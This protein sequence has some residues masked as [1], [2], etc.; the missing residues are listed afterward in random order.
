MHRFIAMHW[1]VSAEAPSRQVEAWRAALE[2]SSLG[3]AA[4]LDTP[5]LLVLAHGQRGEPPVTT[6][7]ADA[8][9]V[10]VGPLFARGRE[11]EGR[12]QFLCGAST[13]R[14]LATAGDDLLKD[15]WGQYVAL[16]REPGAEC[17]T[18]VRDPCGAVSCFR[19][20]TAGVDLL[21]SNAA[22]I[23]DLPGVTTSIDWD[24]L[25]AFLLHSYFTTPH[26]GIREMTE[27]LAGQRLVL[28]GNRGHQLSWAWTAIAFAADP[29]LRSLGELQAE[30]RE[31]TIAC[32]AALATGRRRILVQLSGGLD[33]SILLAILRRVSTCEVIA[34]HTISN[35]YEA[36]EFALAHLV[37][38]QTGTELVTLQLDP[39]GSDLGSIRSIPKL[40]RPS[41]QIVGYPANQMIADVCERYEVDTSMAGHGGDSL[42]LQRSATRNTVSDYLQ[43]KGLGPDAWQI[44]YDAAVLEERS[45]WSILKQALDDTLTRS[46]WR[47][48]ADLEGSHESQVSLFKG[49]SLKDIPESYV[50]H[51][52]LDAAASL[53][54][55]KAEHLAAIVGLYN[56]YVTLG[57][58]VWFDA[59]N[60][61]VSQPILELALRIPTYRFAPGGYDRA[62]QR[63]AFRDL[64]PEAIARRTGKGFLNHHILQTARRNIGF[65][66]ELVLEGELV[67]HGLIDREAADTL[68][69][70]AQFALG[71]GLNAVH[72]LV[73]AEAWLQAWRT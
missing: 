22:D 32:V 33:S 45:V 71:G 4:V 54:R 63:N 61:Y 18:I 39:E 65:L 56:Y 49:L 27:L 51:P 48:Y 34:L 66:R 53:P 26:T 5:G 52:W 55:G 62:L 43:L 10:I 67:K 15:Y 17:V 11:T 14:I 44:A 36:Y 58:G 68:L 42:F 41:R 46:G 29:D 19:M 9:G 2:Q 8:Q 47:P 70:P 37:A 30:L 60:P 1:D 57:Y 7:M 3:W 73:A 38:E 25:R 20:H 16:W 50:S 64:I 59:L 23:A 69:T 40:A 13:R 24:H 6:T 31:T 72:A 12:R 35:S 28:K 21:F